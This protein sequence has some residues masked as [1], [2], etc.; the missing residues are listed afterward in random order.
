MNQG[1]MIRASLHLRPGYSGGPLVDVHGHLL[2][3]HTMLTG[4]DVGLYR[5]QGCRTF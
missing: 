5:Y 3:V 2:G 4:P 1:D